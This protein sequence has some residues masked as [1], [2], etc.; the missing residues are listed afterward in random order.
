MAVQFLVNSL[1]AGSGIALVAI[2]FSL[3]YSATGFFNLAHGAVYLAGAYSTYAVVVLAGWSPIAGCACGIVV[4]GFMG[5]LMEL[6]LYR[7]L[8]KKGAG[9]LVLLLSSLGLL[10]VVQN[11]ISLVFGEQTLILRRSAE[12]QVLNVFGARITV[13][14][15]SIILVSFM[16]TLVLWCILRFTRI[17]K[18]FRAVANDPELALVVGIPSDR[19]IVFIFGIGSAVAGLAAIM[20][21][22]DTD[23]NP[24]MGFNA[25]LLGIV[26][27]IVGGT[28]SVVGGLLGGLLVGVARHFGVWKLPTEWQDAIVFV[29]LILFLLLRPQ[30]FLGKLPRGAAV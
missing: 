6:C 7:G 20:T 3:I 19:I 13:V 9:P 8:R 2:S 1:V 18:M 14:Q 22:Y 10:I 12:L 21:A 29:I 25:L 26:A 5:C 23:L 15:S 11:V 28:R 30:G 24:M 4:A 16:V 27:A 17:G